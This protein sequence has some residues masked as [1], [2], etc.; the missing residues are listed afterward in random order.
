MARPGVS[1]DSLSE[2][3]PYPEGMTM[4]NP[5]PAQLTHIG[6]YVDDMDKMAS[7]YQRTG[8]QELAARL[9]QEAGA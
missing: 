2:T 9:G 1:V 7:F 8:Q 4:S 5:P 6:L 3:T